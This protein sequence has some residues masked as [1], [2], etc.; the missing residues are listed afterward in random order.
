MGMASVF[1]NPQIMEDA[2]LNAGSSSDW[3][4]LISNLKIK[5]V[6]SSTDV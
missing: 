1:N 5:C 3:S 4:F 6:A 2:P